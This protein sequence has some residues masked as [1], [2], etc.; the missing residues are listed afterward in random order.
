MR[1]V[2]AR[3]FRLLPMFLSDFGQRDLDNSIPHSKD[4]ARSRPALSR[5]QEA[6]IRDLDTPFVPKKNL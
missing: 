4:V 2:L 3:P 1:T 5:R 6:G